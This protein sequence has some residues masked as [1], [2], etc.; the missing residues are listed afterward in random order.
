M[1]VPVA[2][3]AFANDETQHLPMLEEE[4]R[5]LDLMLRDWHMRGLIELRVIRSASLKDI[6]DTINQYKDRIAIFHYSGHA[7][8]TKLCLE[9][10]E[11][12]AFGIARMLATQAR[13]SLQLVYLNGC[14]T[15]EHVQKLH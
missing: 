10:E 6:Y 12:N 15:R 13:S 9:D 2:F 3:L 4:S 11:A 8:S 7:T 14:S 5:N 1:P